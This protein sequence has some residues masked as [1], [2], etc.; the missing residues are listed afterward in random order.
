MKIIFT[1]VCVHLFVL[2]GKNLWIRHFA[3]NWVWLNSAFLCLNL[4]IYFV[5]VS[6]IFFCVS[7]VTT[8][9]N[10]PKCE[11]QKILRTQRILPV[12]KKK[13]YTET[14]RTREMR[15]IYKKFFFILLFFKF[16]ILLS[17]FPRSFHVWIYSRYW[18]NV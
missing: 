16:F 2:N 13:L 18:G 10:A 15:R 12:L 3:Q 4:F 1:G 5:H 14:R 11:R 9:K 8:H 17:V 7:N 6:L